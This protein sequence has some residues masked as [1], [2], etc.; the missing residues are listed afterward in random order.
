MIE[1]LLLDA[2][3]VLQHVGG[4]GWRD[5]IFARLR[6][7]TDDFVAA[8]AEVEAPALRGEGP[9]PEPLAD[10]L[11]GFGLGVDTE[12]LYAAL[13][14]SITVDQAVLGI[15]REVREAGT[16]VHL[17]TNQHPRRAALMQRTLGYDEVVDSGFY[18]CEVGVAKPEVG[19]FEAILGRLGARP[20][21]V[22]FVDDS[23]ANVETARG[24]GIAAIQWHLD[25]GTDVLRSRLRDVGVRLPA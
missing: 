11:D 17:A 25:D 24:L 22:A 2:D 6:Q 20:E 9:F 18:S 23:A 19:F 8:V 14:E 16:G 21:Q 3:G 1:H 15:A 12:E 4:Q 5:E 7:R 10:V 13:W